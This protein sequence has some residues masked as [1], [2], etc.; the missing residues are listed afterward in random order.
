MYLDLIK[1]ASLLIALAN[2][3]SMLARIR[4]QRSRGIKILMGLLFGA[5]AIVGMLIPFNYA[6]GIFYDGRSIILTLAG[7]FGGGTTAIVS[8]LVAGAFR[9]SLG[10]NGVWAGLATIIST[11]MV[12]LA[13]RRIQKNHPE[14]FS[15]P[16]LYAIGMIAHIAMLTSQLLVLPWPAGISIIQKI[17]L[18]VMLIFPVATLLISI[19]IRDEDRRIQTESALE[20]SEGLYHDLVETAQDLD[21]AV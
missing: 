16:G 11:A 7:L 19:L 2:I 4:I 13:F 15:I 9:A 10:G 6:P 8:I 18:P 3:Y 20:K 14:N 1:N 21:L 5:G 17:W 12:G